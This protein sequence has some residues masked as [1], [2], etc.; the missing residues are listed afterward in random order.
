MNKKQVFYD[1]IPEH[2]EMVGY[3]SDKI[4]FILNSVGANL[5]I[6]D[7]GC[8]NG[9]IG[10][11]LLKQH[12][13]VYGI[14]I[15]EHKI[16]L[17]RKRGVKASILDVENQDLPF[18]ANYFDVV[19]LTDVIE[20]VF[21]TDLLLEKIYRVLKPGGKL[22]ITTPNVASLGRRLMLLLGL[23][24]FLEYSTHY[25]D[26]VPCPVGHIRYYTHSD[27]RRQLQRHYFHNVILKGDRINFIFFSNPFASKL[28]P[29]LSVDILCSCCK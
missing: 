6:L 24:P 21:D 8:N 4:N 12:N 26:F 20:H 5:R 1:K 17:A 19:L 11:L 2:I 18:K 3:N 13:D 16:L 29:S 15:A 25:I 9:S 23:N 28:F 7:V 22:L 27:L 10:S 14:D